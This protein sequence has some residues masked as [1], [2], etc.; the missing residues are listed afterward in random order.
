MRRWWQ[1][2]VRRVRYWLWRRKVQ[3]T[4]PAG[5]RLVDFNAALKKH[6]SPARLTACT[7][8]PP[9]ERCGPMFIEDDATKEQTP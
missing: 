7:H 9:P 3:R 5:L 2:L 8:Y 6:Y 4:M 1:R